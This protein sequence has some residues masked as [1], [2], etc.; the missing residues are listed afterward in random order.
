MH[1]KKKLLIFFK[2]NFNQNKTFTSVFFCLNF[3]NKS[4]CLVDVP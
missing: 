1:H 4:I 3:L 2:L